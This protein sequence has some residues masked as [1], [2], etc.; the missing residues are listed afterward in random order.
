MLLIISNFS[1]EITKNIIVIY[2][3]LYYVTSLNSLISSSC[4]LVDSYYFLHTRSCHL[5]IKSLSFPPF[6][7]SI[8]FIFN[9]LITLA[10]T[11]S[12]MLNSREQNSYPYFVSNSKGKAFSFSL[13]GMMRVTG[14]FLKISSIRLKK[15]SSI[16]VFWAF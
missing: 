11:S 6:S 13:F 1:L 4:F 10:E 16:L 12:T 7:I 8:P 3:D 9:C 2:N 14:L 5:W 15:F